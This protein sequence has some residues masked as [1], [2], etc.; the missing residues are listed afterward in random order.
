MVEA[1]IRSIHS[2]KAGL[3]W[4]LGGARVDDCIAHCVLHLN[5]HRTSA[6]H[7]VMSPAF[8]FMGVKPNYEKVLGLAFGN[9]IEVYDGTTNK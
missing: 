1:K 7:G 9:Y 5:L 3:S 8:F 4:K 6:L 2:T